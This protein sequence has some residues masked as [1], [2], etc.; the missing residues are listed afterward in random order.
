MSWMALKDATAQALAAH[1]QSSSQTTHQQ[2]SSP[3]AGK[4]NP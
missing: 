1:E 3:T 2:S 4:E